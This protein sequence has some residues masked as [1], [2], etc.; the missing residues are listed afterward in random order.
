MQVRQLRPARTMLVVLLASLLFGVVAIPSVRAAGVD[1]KI[2]FQ[3]LAAA[4]PAGYLRDSGEGYGLRA[5]ADQGSSSLNYGW[6]APSTDT[7]RDLSS[8]GR[9]RNK[10]VADQRLD[11]LIHMQMPSALGSWELALPNGSYDVTVAA[12]DSEIP[13]STDFHSIRVE[14]VTAISQF[15]PS[16]GN[17]TFTHHATAAVRVTVSDGKLTID[18]TGGTNTKINYVDIASA[19]TRPSVTNVTPANN[20]TN[21]L[22]N[23]GIAANVAV[24]GGS[25]NSA[26]VNADTVRL[27]NLNTGVVV[28][29]GVNT[30]G[31]GDI[32]TL[33]PSGVLDPNTPYRFDVTDGVK[34]G[35]N[36]TS[37][38]PFSSTF[39][40]GTG[41]GPSGGG[42]SI[43]FTKT[44]N[45][46][47]NPTNDLFSSLLLG[48]DGKVYVASLLGTITR[49]DIKPS[50]G[51]LINP[52]IITTVRTS[53][54]G[55]RAII[56]MAFD[57]AASAGNL[58]LW[59]S[60]NGEYVQNGAPDWTGKISRLSGPNL[61]TK[62]DYV[63]NLPHS[64]KDHMVNSLAFGPDGKLYV[65]IGSNSAMG[66]RD[67]AWGQRPERLLSAAVLQIDTGAI[68][69]PPLDVKTEE[70]GSYNPFAANAQVKIYATGVRNAYDLVWHTNGSLYTPTNGSAAGGNTPAIPAQLPAA[71]NNRING[72]AYTNPT[73]VPGLT[74]V[75]DQNDFLFRVLPG[76]YYGHP[77]PLRCEW[78]LNG[79]N[80]TG[81]VDPV[82]VAQYPVGTQPDPNYRG[83]A[84]DFGQH[85]SP[86]GAIEY[87]SNAFGGSLKGKLLVVRYS[88]NDDII[89]LTPG[90]P[91]NDIVDAQVGLPG[92][93]GTNNPIDLAENPATGDVYVVEL[94]S[95]SR[96]NLLRPLGGSVPQIEVTPNRIVTNDTQ[97]GN[98]GRTETVTIRNSGTAPL[99][100]SSISIIGA[101]PTQ[102]Q[103][104]GTKPTSLAAGASAPVQ[105]AMKATGTGA[106]QA[107][108]KD[109]VL[110]V[111]SND[112]VM[113]TT[114]IALRGLATL[115][116]GGTNEPSLQWILDT[117]Q[118]PVNVSDD[119]P[120]NNLINS[121]TAKQRAPLLGDE[122]DFQQFKRFDNASPVL[123]E[124]LA[125]FGP[126]NNNPVLRFGWYTSGNAA[127]KNE[128]F[129]VSNDPK[130]N[131][132]RLNPVL[133]TGSVLDFDPGTSSFGFYSVWPFFDNRELFGEDALNSFSGAIPHHVRVYPLKNASGTTVPNAY[134][135]AFEEHISGFDY[136]DVVV[137]VRNVKSAT[138]IAAPTANAGD[139]QT[140]VI[141]TPITINGTGSDADGDPLTF[142]WQ[143]TGGPAAALNGDGSSRSF[144]PTSIGTY[145]FTLTVSDP[146]GMIGTDKVFITVTDSPTPNNQVP[147]ANAGSDQTVRIS[148]NVSLN[149]SGSDADGSI[150]G[151][152]WQQT[153]GLAVTLSGDTSAQLSFVA[154]DQPTVLTFSLVVT[155]NQGLASVAD[156]VQIVV[157]DGSVVE[158]T[159]R[160][161]LPLVG[162]E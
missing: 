150:L 43:A 67:G 60:H 34:A 123:I 35:T 28:P 158:N 3:T 58:L 10:N 48:P 38:L 157:T 155:D 149:G 13:A 108:P 102:F 31:G 152:R 4:V 132:Q 111:K 2:N 40:T 124:P 61:A 82:E 19:S 109:A 144:T 151:Y 139:D 12:G 88:L 17:G 113:G 30:S 121:D 117:Y 15:S 27:M 103:I 161:I 129:S 26:T 64:A 71:C 98:A 93:T 99:T 33:T 14:G 92:L 90:G 134:V 68:S 122:V 162:T 65:P 55:S 49:Y 142:S 114:E 56:G 70:G 1:I 107:G 147:T 131:G 24:T 115:G 5:A 77:N 53:E 153:G 110:Q 160:V 52:Q 63:I 51:T 83:A 85:V 104:V 50:D 118:I 94:G 126:T 39:T 16:G 84:Y 57:P 23:T 148:A 97:D 75:P 125:V 119:N 141:G 42:N 25:I 21:V 66:E 81:S 96:I 143:Q 116:N 22:R 11:T 32:I 7:P 89:V 128:L 133:N 29:A 106:D 120:K 76:G 79:G 137:I 112:P 59:V 100:I 154:P 74:N 101:N 6:V 146:G 69:S 138:S 105:V 135:V 72:A 80:P 136:Q 156:E 159:Y 9:D 54:G 91:N 37:F 45:V 47:S 127:A 87:R 62:Q 140:V 36:N 18:A 8:W 95:V 41:G 130:S 78:I 145:E 86:N 73:N 44:R 46:A 20:A